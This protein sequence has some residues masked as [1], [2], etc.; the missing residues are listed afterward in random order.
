M[1]LWHSAIFIASRALPGALGFATAILLTWFLPVDSFGLYGI[2]MAV[3]MMANNVLYEWLGACLTR[4]HET[5]KDEPAFMP[6]IMALFAGVSL[7]AATPVLAA[8]ALGRTGGNGRLACILLFGTVAYG[9]FELSARVQVCRFQPVRYLVMTLLRNGL[10]L[11]GVLVAYLTRSAEATLLYGFAAMLAAGC[12]FLS[13]GRRWAWRRFDLHLAREFAAYGMPVGLMMIFSGLATTV[14]PIMIGALSGYQAV[15]AFTIGL[16]IVQSTLGVISSGI[17]SAGY[18]LAVRAVEGGDPSAVKAA[19]TRNYTVLLALLLPAGV[20]LAALSPGIA[21]IFVQPR[22][23]DALVRTMP[24]LAAGAV[25]M[26][27]RATY[28]DYAFY[29]GKRTGYLI[30]VVGAA[31]VINLC[32]GAALIPRYHELGAAVAMCGAFGVAL[33]HAL[34][35]ARRAYPMPFPVQKTCGIALATGLMAAALGMRP[36]HSRGALG[37]AEQVLCGLTAY[38]ASLGLLALLASG[39]TDPARFLR[40]SGRLRRTLATLGR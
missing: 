18:P 16:T 32:A 8:A 25:L 1:F 39:I 27:L 17:A 19:L 4:W 31:A 33:A 29:L 34:F 14:T 13:G 9:W 35:L 6:T 7:A 5:H 24:W 28:V 21:D 20:G 23:H 38:S 11:A 22:Y 2:G 37:L 3:V 10:I 40:F 26:G 12:L 30:Q 15:G 36:V